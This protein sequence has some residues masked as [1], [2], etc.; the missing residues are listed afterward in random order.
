MAFSFTETFESKGEELVDKIKAIISQ[1]TARKIAIHDKDGKE[2]ISFPLVI[3]AAAAL[4]APRVAAVAAIAALLSECKISVERED[5][6]GN[7][8]DESLS[9]NP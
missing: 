9:V 8:D 3:G 5:E 7:E 2:I 1:G 4:L 6:M